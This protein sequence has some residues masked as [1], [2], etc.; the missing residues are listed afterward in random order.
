VVATVRLPSLR[1]VTWPDGI[2]R[3]LIPA[4]FLRVEFISRNTEAEPAEVNVMLP[5]A[6]RAATA[7]GGTL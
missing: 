3:L 5:F 1:L 6:A 4:R 7:A 2:G